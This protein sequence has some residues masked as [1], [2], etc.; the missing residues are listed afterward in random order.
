MTSSATHEG[1]RREFVC[2]HLHTVDELDAALPMEGQTEDGQARV[3]RSGQITEIWL[4]KET[5]KPATG[6]GAPVER[7]ERHIM[8]EKCD[9]TSP[10]S[11][12]LWV[13]DTPYGDNGRLATE[14]R[15][16]H[17]LTPDEPSPEFPLTETIGDISWARDH[18][19]GAEPASA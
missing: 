17:C 1:M 9:L 16:L 10:G 18:I 4:D 14:S 11:T 6:A 8:I 2:R 7:Y 3:R 12:V 19:T 15:K 5:E 13:A